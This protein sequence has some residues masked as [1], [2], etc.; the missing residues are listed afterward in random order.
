M[1]ECRLC[2]TI[3]D[4]DA[5]ECPSCGCSPDVGMNAVTLQYGFEG[6]MALRAEDPYWPRR[7]APSPHIAV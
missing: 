4:E 6:V 7:G 1:K 2:R 3:M 5:D